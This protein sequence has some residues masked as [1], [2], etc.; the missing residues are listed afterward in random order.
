MFPQPGLL[1]AA[2]QSGKVSPVSAATQ[3]SVKKNFSAD[4]QGYVSTGGKMYGTP[5]DA[6]VK[7]YIW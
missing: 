4:W 1:D 7:G 5:L 3:A 2:I 6:N